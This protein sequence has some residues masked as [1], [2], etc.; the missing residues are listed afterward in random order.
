MKKI[1]HIIL[2]VVLYSAN[3]MAQDAL[4]EGIALKYLV[5]MPTEKS[6]HP[7]M[8]VLLH[9]YGSDEKDLFALRT[10]CPK[11]DVI[12]SA[13]AP[14]PIQGG[15]YK[16]YEMTN[17]N[18]VHDGNA[19]QLANSR[20]LIDKFITQVSSAYHAD[21]ARIYLMGFSQGAIMSYRVGLTNPALLKGIGVLSGTIY[22][23]LKPMVKN[24]RALKQLSIFIAHGEADERISFADGKA[25]NEYLK[26][27]GLKPSFHSYAEMGHTIS[28]DVLADLIQWLSK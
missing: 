22:P 3:A 15:G 20:A 14:Y 7:P 12:V 23:S 17:V 21:P 10:F 9:G 18:G 27:L 25:A 4:Q 28:R 1:F 19:S 6:A 11:N 8:V 24:N 26:T 13:R 5:Q 16:W 2:L